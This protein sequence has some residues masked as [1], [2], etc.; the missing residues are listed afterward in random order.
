MMIFIMLLFF[1]IIENLGVPKGWCYYMYISFNTK[2][3]TQCQNIFIST[4]AFYFE[5]IFNQYSSS[6]LSV[7]QKFETQDVHY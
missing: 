6:T 3:H 4:L 7:K 5:L 2:L 1:S